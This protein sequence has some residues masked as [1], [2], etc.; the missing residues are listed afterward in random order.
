MLNKALV[1]IA[2]DE[3]FIA[4][5]LAL[6]IEDVGGTVVGPA[7]TVQEALALIDGQTVAA[8]ILDVNLGAH[9]ISPV[10]EILLTLNV[11]VILNNNVFY[12]LRLEFEHVVFSDGFFEMFLFSRLIGKLKRKNG[13]H[14]GGIPRFVRHYF[15]PFSFII[16]SSAVA[17]VLI[18]LNVI[19]Y[20]SI[21]GFLIKPVLGS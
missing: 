13:W 20:A 2:E 12:V 7:A 11:P 10:A 9:D 15:S 3:P 17:C 14:P 1:L 8:A 5:D 4:L 16:V 19:H 21:Q 18:R 6:A